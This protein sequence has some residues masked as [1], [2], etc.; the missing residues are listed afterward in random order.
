MTPVAR[1]V[2]KADGEEMSACM[3]RMLTESLYFCETHAPLF[4]EDRS[5]LSQP[6]IQ[7]IRQA[8]FLQCTSFLR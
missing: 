2:L 5:P 8:P 1:S 3:T 6:F 7:G 4:G